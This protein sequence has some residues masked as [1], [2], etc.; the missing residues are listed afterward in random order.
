[1]NRHL[2]KLIRPNQWLKNAFVFTPL[3]FGRQVADWYYAW[4]CVLAFMAFCLAASGIYCFNDICDAEADRRHPVKRT[5]P[6]ACGAVSKRAACVTMGMAWLMAFLVIAFGDFHSDSSRMRLAGT[7]LLYIVMNVGYCVKL[8]QVAILDVFII[9]TGFVLRI[10]VGGLATGIVLSHWIVLTTFLLALFL[11]LA[12]RRDD[13]A[14]YETSGVKARENTERY[15]MD[16]LNQSFAVLGSMTI[17]CYI[18][19]TVSNDVLERMGNH[20]VYATSVFVLAGILRYMQLTLVDQK[21]GSP[22]KVL[23]HDH[24][25]QACVLGWIVAF[26]FILYL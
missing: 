24:F 15:N 8:K 2:I 6:V 26:T 23:L 13:V 16:F 19:Y 14:I 10:V 1:M 4:P 12:K 3:F 25:I 17:I 18:L 20:Y 9:A 21:S 5:R 22:T 7:L 11:A